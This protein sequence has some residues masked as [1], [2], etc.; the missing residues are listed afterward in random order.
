MCIELTSPY[1]SQNTKEI[2]SVMLCIQKE[3]QNIKADAVNVFANNH[4]YVKLTTLLDYIRPILADKEIWLTQ[5]TI[6]ST[7]PNILNVVTKMTHIPS[8]EWVASLLPVPIIKTDPQALGS[9]LS[10]ARRYSLASMLGIGTEDDDG[11]A[12]ASTEGK[13]SPGR[14]RPASKESSFTSPQSDGVSTG[15]ARQPVTPPQREKPN[16][17]EDDSSVRKLMA[18]LPK[19]EGINYSARLGKDGPVLIASGHT[20]PKGKV[21]QSLGF[22]FSRAH[23]IWWMN[24]A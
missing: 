3:I 23:N 24:V 8:G 17:A 20:A 2:A 11:N 21:L 18:N 10:Y 19:L 15:T 14:K 4:Q 22:K 5:Y 1:S 16:G 9:A 7:H 12:G 13:K 6:E